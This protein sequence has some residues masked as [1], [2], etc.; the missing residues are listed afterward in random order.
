MFKKKKPSSATTSTISLA[1]TV[2]ATTS[3]ISVA[4]PSSA[5]TST[6]SV[7]SPSSA[8]TS[9]IPVASPSSAT[10]ST[11]SVAS[12]SSATASAVSKKIRLDNVPELDD[13][14]HQPKK[15]FPP[16]EFEKKKITKCFFQ[17]DWF[18]AHL[19]IHYE[20]TCDSAFCHICTRT[21][22][23][24]SISNNNIEPQWISEGYT[25][26]KDA[27]CEGGGFKGHELLKGHKKAVER[28]LFF[29]TCTEDVAETLSSKHLVEKSVDRQSN[30][31]RRYRYQETKQVK[32]TLTLA[33]CTIYEQKTTLS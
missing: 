13:V 14:P 12:P 11:I 27:T 15:K 6:I 19:W 32:S 28:I 29:P 3:T 30:P 25:N 10:T 9:T 24:N 8:T 26:W 33:N 4:S 20:E 1:S 21:Y 7:A 5:T 16:R 23:R 22:H 31:G 18:V 17:K 2:S